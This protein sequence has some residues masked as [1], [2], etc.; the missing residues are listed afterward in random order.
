MA[1]TVDH[2]TRIISIPRADLSLIQS[3]PTEIRQLNLQTFHEILRNIEDGV[4]GVVF[5]DT[6]NYA[7]PVEVGGVILAAVIEIINDHTVTFEDGQYAVN[8]V[9]SNSNVGDRVNV[10]QVSVRS[11]N[12]AGLQNL[13]TLLI[14]AYNGEVCYDD[15]RGQGGTD[16]PIGTR[17]TP[18]NNFADVVAIA[19][20]HGIGQIRLLKSATIANQLFPSGMNFVG[21]N[22][23]ETT[24]TL[25]SSASIEGC[26]FTNL[27]ISGVL[28]GA[29]NF[30]ECVI[31]DI[32]YTNGFINECALEGI[33]TL[34]GNAQL[35]LL[36]CWSNVAG[37][38]AGQFA[39]VNMGDSGNSL[40]VRNYSGGLDLQNW[41]GV[42][43]ISI[44]MISGRVIVESDVTGG[45]ITIRGIADV[46]DLSTGTA[47][48]LDQ[49]VNQ[50]LDSL[51]GLIDPDNVAAAVWAALSDLN[52]DSDSFGE[53]M[54]SVLTVN[55]YLALQ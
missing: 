4:V 15:V 8:L 22:I 41:S 14:A 2:V 10:N 49:T 54:N 50:S 18:S 52:K 36:D 46:I 48:V 19:A 23:S 53:L 3:S 21:E 43:D 5:D 40:A 28:D 6:H 45:E 51:V 42:G 31:N 44:D 26:S 16:V 9:G 47:L 24:C 20:L 13:D 25:D 17:S 33:I 1:I 7:A 39:A 35:S 55:K 29:N 11:A 34:G 27:N 12:S 37:A 38:G 30:R 32:N